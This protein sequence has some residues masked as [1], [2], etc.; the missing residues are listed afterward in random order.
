MSTKHFIPVW[1]IIKIRSIKYHQNCEAADSKHPWFFQQLFN[2]I[3]NFRLIIGKNHSVILPNNAGTL[4][5]TEVI[6]YG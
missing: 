4:E 5:A 3:I 6:D 1:R 2:A